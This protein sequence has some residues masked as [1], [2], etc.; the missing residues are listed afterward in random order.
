MALLGQRRG[1][2]EIS[3]FFK[4]KR[5]G[6]MQRLLLE[7]FSHGSRFPMVPLSYLIIIIDIILPYAPGELQMEPGT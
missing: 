4:G 1:E 7:A 2:M 6:T 5:K 3:I